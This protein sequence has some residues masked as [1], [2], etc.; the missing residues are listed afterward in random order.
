M[1]AGKAPH[2]SAESIV[3]R[4]TQFATAQDHMAASSNEDRTHW[5][6]VAVAET[7][8]LAKARIEKLEAAL[9]L[10]ACHGIKRGDALHTIES[11]KRT[12]RNALS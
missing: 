3:D 5:H 10:I 9:R 11:I 12:A 6:H 2:S 7:M 8:N 4:L 1:S